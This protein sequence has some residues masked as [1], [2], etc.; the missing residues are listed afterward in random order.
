MGYMASLND[1]ILFFSDSP[2]TFSFKNANNSGLYKFYYY[3]IRQVQI[4]R[5]G[6]FVRGAVLGS[7][8]GLIS[9][10]IGYAV[11]EIYVPKITDRQS[12]NYNRAGFISFAVT[13][14]IIGGIVGAAIGLLMH[15]TYYI[16]GGKEKFEKMKMD[17]TF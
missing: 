6:D 1:S 15:K 10:G 12:I 13:G 3:K 16:S 7:L 4:K 5:K 2:R 14:V 8:A 11:Y 17:F 9:A